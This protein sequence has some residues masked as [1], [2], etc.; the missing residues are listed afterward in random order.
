M[1]Q[2]RFWMATT[3]WFVEVELLEAVVVLRDL[4]NW[5]EKA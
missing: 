5:H 3:T 1:L 2:P 4:R